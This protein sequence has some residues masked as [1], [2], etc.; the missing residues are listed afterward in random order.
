MKRSFARF[1]ALGQHQTFGG[2]PK[3]RT[4]HT[5]KRMRKPADGHYVMSKA[6]VTQRNRRHRPR[7]SAM[8]LLDSCPIYRCTDFVGWSNRHSVDGKSWSPYSFNLYH[9]YLCLVR[10]P[11]SSFIWLIVHLVSAIAVVVI[12]DSA[13]TRYTT[14]PMVT[15]L[16]DTIYPISSVPFPAISICNNNRISRRQAKQYAARL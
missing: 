6:D 16:F 9:P 12:L 10:F 1:P 4:H 3:S 5:N 7:V 11:P 15:T 13:Y 2:E 8:N 14:T